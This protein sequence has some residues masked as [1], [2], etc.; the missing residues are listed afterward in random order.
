[1]ARGPVGAWAV[2]D[3]GALENRFFKLAGSVKRLETRLMI[4]M[5]SVSR[6]SLL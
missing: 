5:L 1:M 6:L 3:A 2:S 4:D